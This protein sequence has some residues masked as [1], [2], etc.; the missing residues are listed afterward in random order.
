MKP[1]QKITIVFFASLISG[2][3]Q[4]A[5]HDRGGGLIY[6]DVLDVTWLQ[7]ANHG[8]GSS[9][10]YCDGGMCGS[11]TDGLMN[12]QSA[13]DWAA[14][15]SYYDSLRDVTYSD[16][17]LPTVSLLNGDTFIGNNDPDYSVN[18]GT[19]ASELAYMFFVNLGNPGYEY[20]Y[21]GQPFVSACFPGNCLQNSGPF[22]N[23]AS[24][25]YWSGSESDPNM[26]T[27]WVF[28][29][30]DG[31]QS[32]QPDYYEGYAWAVRDGDVAAVPEADTWA[33]LLTGLVLVGGAAARR[34][35]VDAPG[36]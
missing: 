3:A 26:G 8:A 30:G 15:L 20:L 2:T 27:A 13:K 9:F 5:L 6:D 7:D 28:N 14:D 4:A 34:R 35:L 19:T 29:M 23:L 16:W 24:S 36:S 21:R 10:D 12:W 33:L 22:V 18:A 1:K 31:F 32:G 11:S 17:R 25:W